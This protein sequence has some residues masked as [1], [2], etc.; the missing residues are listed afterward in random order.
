[1]RICVLTSLFSSKSRRFDAANV[2]RFLFACIFFEKIIRT[3]L[4]LETINP[5]KPLMGKEL[6]QIHSIVILVS[7]RHPLNS[8][9]RTLWA[10]LSRLALDYAALHQGAQ[11]NRSI[12]YAVSASNDPYSIKKISPGFLLVKKVSYLFRG[13]PYTE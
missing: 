4:N 2:Q 13:V 9:G 11:T 6:R 10:G 5:L 1:M 3:D 7:T 12:P 8:S